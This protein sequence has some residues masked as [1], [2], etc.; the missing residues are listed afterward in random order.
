[1]QDEA[2]Y[3][4]VHPANVSGLDIGRRVL[5]RTGADESSPDSEHHYA[6]ETV[7]E[8]QRECEELKSPE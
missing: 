5:A 2:L 3:S 7:E 8:K 4:W 1:M 6:A